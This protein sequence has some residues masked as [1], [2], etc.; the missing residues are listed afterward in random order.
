MT[1]LFGLVDDL[2]G[3]LDDDGTKAKQDATGMVADERDK[4]WF[5]MTNSRLILSR[6]IWKR[7][8]F[9]R[10]EETLSPDSILVPDFFF[11]T[12]VPPNSVAGNSEDVV[13]ERP[14]HLGQAEDNQSLRRRRPAASPMMQHWLGMCLTPDD[15]DY[16]DVEAYLTSPSA[17]YVSLYDSTEAGQERIDDEL[18]S[19]HASP[20]GEAQEE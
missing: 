19:G 9:D 10:R 13:V 15:E 5:N 8:W 18:Y 7:I 11:E 20:D 2:N 6:G 17:Y 1:G 3:I 16:V 4:G 12:P 14:S